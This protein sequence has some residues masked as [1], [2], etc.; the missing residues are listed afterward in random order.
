MRQSHATTRVDGRIDTTPLIA[1]STDLTV[2]VVT[3]NS[4]ATVLQSVGSVLE[5]VRPGTRI[6]V[7]DNASR[8]ATIST[9]SSAFGQRIELHLL[10]TN[11]GYGAA[12]NVAAAAATTPWLLFMNADAMLASAGILAF[13]GVG[14]DSSLAAFSPQLQSAELEP[15]PTSFRF[16]ERFSLVSSVVANMLRMSRSKRLASGPL[17]GDAVED[18][19]PCDWVPGAC[20][21]VR[22]DVFDAIGGFDEGFFLYF[23]DID[24]CFR[25][26]QA[27]YSVA[28]DNRQVTTHHKYGSASQLAWHRFVWIR[29]ASEWRYF[30]VRRASLAANSWAPPL[31]VQPATI[32]PAQH[33]RGAAEDAGTDQAPA[34]KAPR[35]P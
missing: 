7:V 18:W 17:A 6:L 8:D 34:M 12:C 33:E 28:V 14:C 26:K 2:V 32:S 13:D 27:G 25:L 10:P 3:H 4:S 23:E 5:R 11:V 29:V 16:P 20:M 31:S 30:H 19:T 1:S 22:H 15:V 9:V 21:F 35:R 24:L